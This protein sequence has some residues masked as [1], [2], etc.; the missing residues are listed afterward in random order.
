MG[1]MVLLVL[2]A[3]TSLALSFNCK[4]DGKLLL[5][6]GWSVRHWRGGGG[7]LDAR[8]L[9]NC[10][11]SKKYPMCIFIMIVYC[12]LIYSNTSLYLF[13]CISR[14]VGGGDQCGRVSCVGCAVRDETHGESQGRSECSASLCP[15]KVPQAQRVTLSL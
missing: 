9:L 8:V 2:T 3:K 7:W 13:L 11:N 5:I 4:V 1:G 14:E 6:F 12:S 10:G 15:G